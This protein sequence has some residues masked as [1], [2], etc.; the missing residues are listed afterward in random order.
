MDIGTGVITGTLPAAGI[1]P[2]SVT[3]QDSVA[4]TDIKSFSLT[5]QE[6]SAP[7]L[8]PLSPSPSSL[9]TVYDYN[10]IQHLTTDIIGLGLDGYGQGSQ[11]SVPVSNRKRDSALRWDNLIKDVSFINKHITHVNTS[12]L[13]PSTGTIIGSA[14]PNELAADINWLADPVRRY[15]CHPLEYYSVN[16]TTTNTLNGTSTRTTVWSKQFVHKVRADFPTN[17]FARYFFNAGGMFVWR[18]HFL[19]V[20]GNDRDVEWAEFLKYIQAEPPYEYKRNN[21]INTLTNTTVTTYTS[22]SMTV[23]IVAERRDDITSTQRIDFS[24]TFRNNDVSDLIVYPTTGYWNYGPWET[25]FSSSS[26]HISGVQSVAGAYSAQGGFSLDDIGGVITLYMGA[27][28]SDPPNNQTCNW[29]WLAFSNYGLDKTASN[30]GSN[31]YRVTN[32]IRPYWTMW[33]SYKLTDIGIGSTVDYQLP[34]WPYTLVPYTYRI[35]RDSSNSASIEP[36]PTAWDTGDN[37]T[38]VSVSNWVNNMIAL[39]G[40]GGLT[41]TW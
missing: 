30:D 37:G 34:Y 1:S 9:I 16:N 25:V 39:Q 21:F 6:I 8:D 18:P 15:T 7:P 3:V 4:A 24:A 31:Y 2:I 32:N 35:T 38:S 23:S 40:T 12:T 26:T 33:G 28:P 14:L 27:W 10:Y 17:R 19:S 36:Y 41:F 5:I 11:N 20:V 22:G 29:E 13:A